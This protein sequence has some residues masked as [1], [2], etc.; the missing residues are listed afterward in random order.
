[1]IRQRQ[2]G[3]WIPWAFAG[4]F[5]V[6]LLANGIMAAIAFGTWTGL[7]TTKAYQEG[8]AYNDTLAERANQADLGW[9]VAVAV[10]QSAEGLAQVVVAVSDATGQPIQADG[11]QARF[12]RPTH[13][14]FDQEAALAATGKGRYGA[15]V[16]L[17]LPG[18]WDVRLTV[19]RGGDVFETR[20]RIMVG[21]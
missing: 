21:S 8:V 14:G 17:P 20:R 2:S 16:A 3:W 15:A 9:R 18:Q 13:G 19:T 4:F 5:A 11:V 10:E 12:V 6:V 7:T 1:M